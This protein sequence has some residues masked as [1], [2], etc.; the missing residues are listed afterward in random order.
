MLARPGRLCRAGAALPG[1]FAEGSCPPTG[2]LG[3]F[4]PGKNS[5]WARQGSDAGQARPGLCRAGYAGQVRRNCRL[6]RQFS[7]KI[8]L[9]RIPTLARAMPGR[10]G[11]RASRWASHCSKVATRH[12][13]P[14]TACHLHSLRVRSNP[15]NIHSPRLPCYMC[16]MCYMAL[17]RQATE[18]PLSPGS[19]LYVLYVLYGP[20]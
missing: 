8:F 3:I 4:F 11:R 2:P 20:I 7:K 13:S 16:Y 17:T 19:M 12:N 14:S 10:R 18:H 9:G 1:R 15:P 5:P 6:R